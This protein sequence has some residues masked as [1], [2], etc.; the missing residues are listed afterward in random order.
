VFVLARVLSRYPS[1]PFDAR[2]DTV[3]EDAI[4]DA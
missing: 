3:L 1:R 4:F 2:E